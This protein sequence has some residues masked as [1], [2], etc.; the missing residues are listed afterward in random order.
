MSN[1]KDN[2]DNKDN[3]DNNDNKDKKGKLTKKHFLDSIEKHID[4]EIKNE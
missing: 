1:N 3:N 2:K 4:S